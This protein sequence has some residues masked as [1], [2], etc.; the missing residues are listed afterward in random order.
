M[1]DKRSQTKAASNDDRTPPDAPAPAA[2][3]RA[4]VWRD[5][6]DMIR[7]RALAV[8]T[9]LGQ[10]AR[11]VGPDQYSRPCVQALGWNIVR[12]VD[13]LRAA[14]GAASEMD[15]VT[16]DLDELRTGPVDCLDAARECL[17]IV[18]EHHGGG[19][20]DTTEEFEHEQYGLAVLM[21]MALAF[22]NDAETEFDRLADRAP[23]APDD[24]AIPGKPA[25]VASGAG[26]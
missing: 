18:A 2:P 25:L 11:R 10:A 20:F 7:H 8:L 6:P 21:E 24:G 17:M 4:A 16:F 26:G 19:D 5:Q 3:T 1:T 15:Y 13:A 14:S 22:L 12:M 9:Y 23:A